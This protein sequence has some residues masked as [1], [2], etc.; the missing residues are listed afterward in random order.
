MKR[1]LNLPDD[2]DIFS[3]NVL[4]ISSTALQN[5]AKTKVYFIIMYCLL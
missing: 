5:T 2:L 1:E 3:G 4:K